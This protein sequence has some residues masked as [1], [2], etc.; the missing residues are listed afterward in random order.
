MRSRLLAAAAAAALVCCLDGPVP[1]G[2]STSP[3]SVAVEPNA[4]P[5][6]VYQFILSARR[7]LDM[8]MYEL[9]DPM[10]EHDLAADA[11]RG[12]R[13]RVLLD[14]DYT[15]GKINQPAAAYLRTTGVQTKF[16]PASV[17]VHQKTIVVDSQAAMIMTGNLT[18]RYYP[19]SADFAVTDRQPTDVATVVR[20][21]NDDWAGDLADR[22]YDVPVQGEQGDLIFSP[23][24]ETTLISLIRSARHTLQ[25]SSEEMDSRPVEKALGTAVRDGVG[26]QVLMTADPS[27][28]TAFAALRAAGVQIRLYAASAH[29]Y[30]HAKCIIVDSATVYVGSINFSSSSLYYNRELGVVTADQAVVRPVETAW[31]GWWQGA[32]KA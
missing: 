12:V 10:A 18:S 28:D 2:A 19:T 24:S 32:P 5:A 27:W 6:P 25:I 21:F 7:S 11:A 13:V 17:I 9:S 23:E 14:Q 16:A 22:Y 26:V 1:A 15:G 30:I 20:A 31:A 3:F 4:G 29:L 8:T